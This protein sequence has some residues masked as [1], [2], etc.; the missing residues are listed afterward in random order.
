MFK[1]ILTTSII[2][3]PGALYIYHDFHKSYPIEPSE[4]PAQ[5]LIYIQNAGG[6]KK[7]SDSFGK[8]AQD[9]KGFGD[10]ANQFSGF[11]WVGIYYDDPKKVQEESKQ[12]AIVGFF[13]DPSNKTLVNEFLQKYPDYSLQE[14]PKINTMST[15]IALKSPLTVLYNF[16]KTHPRLR[17]FVGER[18]LVENAD[19][20]PIIEV[21]KVENQRMSDIA[22]HIPIDKNID[23]IMLYKTPAAETPVVTKS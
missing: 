3:I 13:L 4:I 12:R 16:A 2:V 23:K 17:K 20:L 8:L 14:I 19:A 15:S 11:K 5:N 9:M 1:K 21:Y 18:D 10:S 7:L 6:Y 22:S